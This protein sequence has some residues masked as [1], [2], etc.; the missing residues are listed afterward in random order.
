MNDRFKLWLSRFTA[1][2]IDD[3][4]QYV[5]LLKLARADDSLIGGSD[6]K[7]SEYYLRKVNMTIDY[8]TQKRIG[9]SRMRQR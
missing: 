3:I 6:M 1:Q 8:I 5:Y 2:E 4:L 9:T 7:E